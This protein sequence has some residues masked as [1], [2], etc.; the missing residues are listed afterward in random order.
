MTSTSVTAAQRRMI[1][2]LLLF[3]AALV[4]LFVGRFIQFNDTSGFGGDGAILA[5]GALALALAAS[6][7]VVAVS[8]S[9]ARRGLGL[10]I[11]VLDVLLVVGAVADEGFRF[12]WGDDEGELFLLQVVLGLVALVL[13]VPR[14]VVTEPS[15]AGMLP[16]RRL[17]G[18]ARAAGYVVAIVIAAFVA[19]DAGMRHFESTECS[20][21]DECDLGFLTAFVWSAIAIGVVV[22]VAIGY[23]FVRAAV[24]HRDVRDDLRR[25]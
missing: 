17:S 5:L 18:W 13:L 22:V 12:I 23:E 14:F 15:R 6:A 2:A 25:S 3:D 16:Q 24:N 9:L 21:G 7:V 4:V 19:F 11:A 1:R 10:S 8:E 20:R